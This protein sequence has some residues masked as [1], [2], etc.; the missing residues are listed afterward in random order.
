MT[1]KQMENQM[2][3]CQMSKVLELHEI[4]KFPWND[5]VMMVWNNT[6][7]EDLI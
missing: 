3:D 2:N 1:V 7:Y 5:A 4:D 6:E